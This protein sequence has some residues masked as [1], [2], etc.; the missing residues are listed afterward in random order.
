[1]PISKEQAAAIVA[2]IMADLSD[3]AGFDVCDVDDTT[4]DEWRDR[5]I[6]FV[7]S[8]SA[9]E[10]FVTSRE[11]LPIA[12]VAKADPLGSTAAMPMCIIARR[13]VGSVRRFDGVDFEKKASEFYAGEARV[14]VDVMLGSLPGGT[15][16]ALLVRLLD[17]KRSVLAVSHDDIKRKV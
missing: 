10:V 6:D 14:I 7:T 15:I 12:E 13:E 8:G 2:R 1:M 16:D 17:H 9:S 11:S 5:W 4:I 3:R